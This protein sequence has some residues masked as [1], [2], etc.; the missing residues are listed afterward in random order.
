MDTFSGTIFSYI[1]GKT[2]AE[3]GF[4]PATRQARQTFYLNDVYVR[5]IYEQ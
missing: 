1:F 2:Q 3:R 5:L 4:Y